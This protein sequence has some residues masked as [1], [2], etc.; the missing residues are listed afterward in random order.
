MLIE[1]AGSQSFAMGIDP[2]KLAALPDETVL[3]WHKSGWLALIHFHLASLDNFQALLNRR[4]RRM[5]DTSEGQDAPAA[6]STLQ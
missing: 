5:A 1:V 6:A 3:A 2:E 4:G